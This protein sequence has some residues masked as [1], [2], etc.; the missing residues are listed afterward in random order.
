MKWNSKTVELSVWLRGSQFWNRWKKRRINREGAQDKR[1]EKV[2][3]LLWIG[4]MIVVLQSY[5]LCIISYRNF[6][7]FSHLTT[8]LNRIISYMIVD[9]IIRYLNT[10]FLRHLFS[11]FTY[12]APTLLARLDLR[13]IHPPVRWWVQ[14]S[15]DW[16]GPERVWISLLTGKNYIYFYNFTNEYISLWILKVK[17]LL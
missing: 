3:D 10:T 16:S 13:G 15:V 4:I 14:S 2:L 9:S 11:P 6:Y 7:F 8:K 17:Y 1:V 12:S 5:Y